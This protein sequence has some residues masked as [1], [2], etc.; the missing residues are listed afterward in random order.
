MNLN[1]TT[2][3]YDQLTAEERFRLIMAAKGR[4]DE[5]ERDRLVRSAPRH[6]YHMWHHEPYCDAFQELST[7]IFLDIVE[8]ATCQLKTWELVRDNFPDNGAE[9]AAKKHEKTFRPMWHVFTELALAIGYQLRIRRDG[10]ILFCERL[11]V[12]PFLLWENLTGFERLQDNLERCDKLD[13]FSPQGMASWL[14]Y[15]RQTGELEIKM[16]ELETPEIIA[17]ILD[18]RFRHGVQKWLGRFFLP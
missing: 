7:L 17:R 13:I 1:A 6:S 15:V 12:P 5:A 3:L 16:E 18:Q 8:F 11:S 4:G 9:D 2:K 14:N 10:W